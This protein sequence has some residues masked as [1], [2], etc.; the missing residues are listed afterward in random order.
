M[1]ICVIRVCA[2]VQLCAWYKMLVEV[3][4]QYTEKSGLSLHHVVLG[5]RIQTVRLD[6]KWLYLLNHLTS[7]KALKI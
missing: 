2:Y 5:D 4:G 6:S 7:L 1:Y 3:K